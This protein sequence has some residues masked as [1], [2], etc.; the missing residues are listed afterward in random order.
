MRQKNR[1]RRRELK[2]LAEQEE[3]EV[4][5]AGRRKREKWN[6]Q[7]RGVSSRGA[8]WASMQTWYFKMVG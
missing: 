3:E 5:V 7:C 2:V 1:K 6:L 4:E 8:E